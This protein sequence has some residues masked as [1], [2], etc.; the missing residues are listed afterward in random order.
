MFVDAK[1]MLTE[2]MNR[3]FKEND[4]KY[5]VWATRETSEQKVAKVVI[6]P[7][8]I[9]H[10]EAVQDSIKRWKDFVLDIKVDLAWIARNVL[11]YGVVIA[12]SS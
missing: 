4:D 3:A 6:A 9:S 8:I 7:L 10:D 11:R 5:R 2:E 1:V 12:G